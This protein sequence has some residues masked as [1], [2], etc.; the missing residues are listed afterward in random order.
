MNE[1]IKKEI[2]KYFL[3]NTKINSLEYG[4]KHKLEMANMKIG[5]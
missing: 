5:E 3:D 1:I 2:R 4:Y